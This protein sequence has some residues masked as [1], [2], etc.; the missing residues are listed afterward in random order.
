MLQLETIGYQIAAK[1]VRIEGV[2]TFLIEGAIIQTQA[3]AA[4]G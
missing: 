4:S 3:C 1:V 2:V